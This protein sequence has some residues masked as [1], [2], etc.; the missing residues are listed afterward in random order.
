MLRCQA[1]IF[2]QMTFV[3]LCDVKFV[4]WQVLHSWLCSVLLWWHTLAGDGDDY[5]DVDA[6]ADVDENNIGW[7][8]TP[9]GSW[10]DHLDKSW[11]DQNPML[12]K[13]LRFWFT[14]WVNRP[15]SQGVCS[16]IQSFC[17]MKVG[18]FDVRSH[19]GCKCNKPSCILFHLYVKTKARS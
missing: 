13:D 12:L 5:S 7:P 19:A 4:I 2:V 18:L 6:D 17:N 15:G 3:M 11:P 8:H 14:L 10:G 9:S 16:Q 1:K